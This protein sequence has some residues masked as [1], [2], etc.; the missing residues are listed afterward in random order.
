MDFRRGLHQGTQ[1][2]PRIIGL[3]CLIFCNSMYTF[4]IS[5]ASM[6]LHF[7][8]TNIGV[9]VANK[10]ALKSRYGFKEAPLNVFNTFISPT[11]SKHSECT[12]KSAKHHH[13][14]A[15]PLD[16]LS[17]HGAPFSVPR[18]IHLSGIGGTKE[19]SKMKNMP[20]SFKG[21]TSPPLTELF[22]MSRALFTTLKLECPICP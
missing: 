12:N 11:R 4:V 3:I 18:S 6:R 21:L 17:V 16:P 14:V 2:L 13:W 15:L 5:N 1:Y 22:W 9:R 7:V 8:E 20:C 19:D 10:L